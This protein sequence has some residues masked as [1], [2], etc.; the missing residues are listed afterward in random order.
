MADNERDWQPISTAP[1]NELVEAVI[2]GERGFR[3]Q[4]EMTRHGR[5][6]YVGTMYVYYTPT[7][8]RKVKK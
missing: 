6:W 2:V 8:W 5:L 1:E 4:Q 3:N 7:H